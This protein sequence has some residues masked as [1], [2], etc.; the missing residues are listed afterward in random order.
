MGFLL[1]IFLFYSAC[2]SSPPQSDICRVALEGSPT[3]LD[4]RYDTGA[5]A[6]RIFPLIYTYLFEM[7][8]TGQVIPLA[9]ESME[10]PDPLTYIVRLKKGIRFH[11]GAELTSKDVASTFRFIKD[12]ANGSPSA[13]GLDMLENVIE[14]DPWTVILQL[15]KPFA[16][17][18]LKLAKAI[19]PAHR[20]G[21]DELAAKPLGAGPYKVTEYRR[22]EKLTLEAFDDYFGGKPQIRKIIFQIISNET[23][24]M[25]K[26]KRGD[27]DLVLNG[28]P[29]YS[30][31]FFQKDPQKKVIRKPGINFSYL[32]FNLQDPKRITSN[33]LVRKAVAHAIDRD[34][35]IKILISGQARKANG[36]LA[37]ENW[38]YA[39]GLTVYEYD[40]VK[41]KRLLDEAGFPNPPGNAPR[42]V[43]SYK[44]STDKLRN[45]I[46]EVIAKQLQEV[47]IKVEKRSFEWGTFFD[48]IKK[49]NFQTYTLSWVGVMDPDALRYIYHSSSQPP[50]GANRGR[51]IN[52]Q[53]DALLDA[54]RA[55]MDLNKRKELYAQV[56]KII[57]ED[58]VVVPLW[59]ADDIVVTQKRLEGFD[60]VPGG[61]YTSLSRA[62][63]I[64]H[65]N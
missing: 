53:V 3:T 20:M 50:R 10:Q 30:L 64:S 16:S 56:Q 46:A 22:G 21:K 32:G 61:L 25:L 35:I 43:L 14:R 58:C 40:P 62:K 60:L 2:A 37:P 28:I 11:D 19:C 26:L 15:S 33:I 36:L 57:A 52:P 63:I 6:T 42:F 17:F 4:P 34:A 31:D 51:Y 47:G 38:A 65:K 48:D 59:W 12:P 49:G 39:T 5:Y 41:S 1:M 23:T 29:P 9:A 8:S 55:E 27:I 13:D 18:P 24:R 54:A 7:D 45:R 44:T